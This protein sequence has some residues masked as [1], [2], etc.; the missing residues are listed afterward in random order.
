LSAPDVQSFRAAHCDTDHYLVVAK[1]AES[2]LFNFALEYN[3][4]KVQ[5]HQLGLKLNGT[6]QLL[7][8]ADM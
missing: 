6:Y 8:Y 5:V 1:V 2:L 7:A 4:K 3:I